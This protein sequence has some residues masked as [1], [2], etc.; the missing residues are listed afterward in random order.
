MFSI[1]WMDIFDFYLSLFSSS[2]SISQKALKRLFYGMLNRAE[3][4][5]LNLIPVLFV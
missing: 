1:D 5:Y 4:F 3:F 2:I